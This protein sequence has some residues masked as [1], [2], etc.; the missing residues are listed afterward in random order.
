MNLYITINSPHQWA[1]V[2]DDQRSVLATGEAQTLN[3][4]KF[5]QPIKIIKLIADSTSVASHR[6]DVPGTS[7]KN[8]INAIPF[9]LEEELTDD[10]DDLH[11]ALQQWAPGQ[12][13]D[14]LVVKDQLLQNSMAQFDDAGFNVDDVIPQYL[15]LPQHPSADITLA[16]IPSGD[17]LI[18]SGNGSGT[19]V[20]EGMLELWWDMEAKGK[21]IALNDESMVKE[22]I[23]AG[24]DNVQFWDI[25]D[26]FFDWIPHGSLEKTAIPC[27]LQGKYDDSEEKQARFDYKMAINFMLAGVG[28]YVCSILANY[29]YLS[30][31]TNSLDSQAIE[32]HE[33]AFPELQDQTIE[34]P[35]YEFR[36]AI[37]ALSSGN[38]QSDN[39]LSIFQVVANQLQSM[40][41][42]LL[43]NLIFEQDVLKAEVIVLDFAALDALYL[44]L[45][46]ITQG[47]AT[48][49][50]KDAAAQDD[51]VKGILEVT[52]T[53]G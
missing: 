2:N 44:S 15:L 1:I 51:V 35:I 53:Q 11:F 7:R 36:K 10:I 5:D 38:Y 16:K 42:T 14:V 21:I 22:F 8:V 25:G 19:I 30:Y 39:F 29:F 24:W 12:S 20:D 37:S 31:K 52:L 40:P 18:R 6:V 13:A 4:L 17:Y 50:T 49:E 34:D 9:V 41:N 28:I 48:V 47:Y 3:E 27:L 26:S 32:M 33:T 45:S 23:A 43:T 46:N